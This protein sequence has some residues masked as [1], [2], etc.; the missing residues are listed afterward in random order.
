MPTMSELVDDACD[1]YVAAMA[2]RGFNPTGVRAETL[3]HYAGVTTG[4]MSTCLQVHRTAQKVA[5][6]TKYV[7]VCEEYGPRARWRIMSKPGTD[8]ATIQQS[9]RQHARYVVE[10]NVRKLMRDQ[11]LEVYPGLHNT[12]ID[13]LIDSASHFAANQ[14]ENTLQ[15]VGSIL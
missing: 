1:Q 15:F 3:A 4:Y 13:T 8:P 11:M 2:G 6:M 10:D 7:L 5:G 9:R 14:F 12:Q